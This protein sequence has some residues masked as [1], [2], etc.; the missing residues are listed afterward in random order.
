MPARRN[1]FF[2]NCFFCVVLV[3]TGLLSSCVTSKQ[4][5]L[6][7]EPTKNNHIP[8]YPDTVSYSD[9]EIRIGDRLQIR[10]HSVDEQVQKLFSTAIGG[11]SNWNNYNN[12]SSYG[13]GYA[14]ELY[15]YLVL[16][17]GTI[18]FPLV[19]RLNVH[20]LNTRQ[21]KLR[22]EDEL[23]T[24]IKDYGEFKMVSADVNVV[25]RMYSVISEGGSGNYAIRREKMTIYEALAQAGDVGDWSDRSK[26][27]II[28]EIEGQTRVMEFDVRSMDIINSEY[29]YVEPNDVIYVQQLRGKA[30]GVSNITTSIS[31][32]ATTISFGGFV[33]G[34]VQRII[35]AANKK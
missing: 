9:Y 12:M 16:E 7:Q 2:R 33:Y 10:V 17:D 4:V 13:Q 34:I 31:V 32:V 27:K 15:T 18:D 11:G 3:L 35:N 23:S 25:Q 8:S 5:N 30:F 22:L 19:G 14:N 26:V 20:G 6:M 24:Y 29:Y 28:R 1:I 21:V